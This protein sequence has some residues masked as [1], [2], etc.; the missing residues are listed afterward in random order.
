MVNQ[1]IFCSSKMMI[2]IGISFSFSDTTKLLQMLYPSIIFIQFKMVGCMVHS[3]W[4]ENPTCAIPYKTT[5]HPCDTLGAI[6]TRF[7]STSAVLSFIR[8]TGLRCVGVRRNGGNTEFALTRPGKGVAR[9]PQV[10][11]VRDWN[12][13]KTRCSLVLWW[14]PQILRGIGEFTLLNLHYIYI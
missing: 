9:W 10:G 8:S 12:S 6:H 11:C 1:I 13:V 3:L 14:S 7:V 2:K 5:E 4:V